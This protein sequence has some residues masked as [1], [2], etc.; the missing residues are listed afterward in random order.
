MVEALERRPWWKK[1]EKV[2]FQPGLGNIQR[3]KEN[4]QPGLANIR[5]G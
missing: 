2:N 1:M 4:I 5:L 3:G